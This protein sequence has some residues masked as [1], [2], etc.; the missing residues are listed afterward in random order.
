MLFT[1][2]ELE[3][4]RGTCVVVPPIF[5]QTEQLQ[6]LIGAD[7][8]RSAS[9]WTVPQWQLPLRRSKLPE[10]LEGVSL[11]TVCSG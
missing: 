1:S 5:M 8:S 4:L 7:R 9:N 10:L 6:R 2:E 3:G 11:M